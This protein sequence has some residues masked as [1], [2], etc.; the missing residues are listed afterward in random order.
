M[1][2]LRFL[3]RVQ[4]FVGWCVE[5]DDASLLCDEQQLPTTLTSSSALPHT[6]ECSWEKLEPAHKAAKNFPESVES[7]Q[8]APLGGGNVANLSNLTGRL[9]AWP[10]T[11]SNNGS[12]PGG[13]RERTSRRTCGRCLH[14]QRR[15][16]QPPTS[17]LLYAQ[18]MPAP[19]NAEKRGGRISSVSTSAKPAS[20]TS[21]ARC[22]GSLP[23]A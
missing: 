1:G 5:V 16:L 10:H 13:N 9:Y 4:L 14:C 2:L 21:A 8:K 17:M 7:A 3:P 20:L 19:G 23:P 11:H 6:A 18:T 12:K 22:C 15:G